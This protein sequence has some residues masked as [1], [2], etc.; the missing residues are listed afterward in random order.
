L[1]GAKYVFRNTR[2]IIDLRN[3]FRERS[4]HLADVNFLESIAS[5]NRANLA[6]EQIIGVE[7]WNAVVYA[8]ARM[9]RTG[10]ARR[11]AD[12]RRPVS[13]PS[14]SAILAAA[15]SCLADYNLNLGY[16]RKASSTSR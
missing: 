16:S 14:A 10:T 9:S 3:P 6:D 13:L 15:P 2:G 12:S 5:L 7:S 8:D 11:E 4:E 1:E